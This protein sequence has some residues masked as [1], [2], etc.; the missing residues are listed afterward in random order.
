MFIEY[1][2]SYPRDPQAEALAH[3][4][5]KIPYTQSQLSKR[6]VFHQVTTVYNDN[7]D[8]GS[9]HASTINSAPSTAPPVF[10]LLRKSDVHAARVEAPTT[11][12]LK[13]DIYSVG[14]II[15][16]KVRGHGH[17]DEIRVEY[18][19]APLNC[20]EVDKGHW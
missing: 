4:H 7:D 2:V 17:M 12:Q 15:D 3:V 16:S 18:G 19:P 9:S 10:H 11:D 1:A 6:Y 13:V 14:V 8:V 5:L 20:Q